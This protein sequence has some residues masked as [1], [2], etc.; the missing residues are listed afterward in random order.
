MRLM[1]WA[2]RASPS[3][4][5]EVRFR[6]IRNVFKGKLCDARQLLMIGSA[7]LYRSMNFT[8]LSQSAVGE[9]V[10]YATSA[11]AAAFTCSRV[12]L[13]FVQAMSG[14]PSSGSFSRVAGAKIA[15]AL[16]HYP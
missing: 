13:S 14:E 1:R 9:I 3:T 6:F 4:E 7:A 2:V 15:A 12:C 11:L 16:I 5:A 10:S 8:K